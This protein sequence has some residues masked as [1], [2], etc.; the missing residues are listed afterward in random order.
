MGLLN[1][2][3]FQEAKRKADGDVSMDG[4][5]QGDLPPS[6]VRLSRAHGW[7][8]LRDPGDERGEG[9]ISNSFEDTSQQRDSSGRQSLSHCCI[10][11]LQP[12]SGNLWQPLQ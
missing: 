8:V 1:D 10:Q 12:H 11:L 5:E 4:L 2:E 9:G 6:R 3:C 7:G